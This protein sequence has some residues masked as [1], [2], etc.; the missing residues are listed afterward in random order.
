MDK[1]LC[2]LLI[3]Y[4]GAGKGTQGNIIGTIRRFYHCA[5]GDVFR[6]Q[7]LRGPLGSPCGCFMTGTGAHAA[8]E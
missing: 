4:P 2:Y 6:A 1:Y 3:G 7:Q 5:C 8:I